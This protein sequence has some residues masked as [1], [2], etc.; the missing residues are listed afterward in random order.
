[1]S[2]C[3]KCIITGLVQGVF[4]RASTEEKANK[5]GVTGYVKNIPE[6]HVEVLICGKPE[7]VGHLKAWLWE[8]PP[9]SHVSNVKCTLVED[10]EIPDTFEI[11]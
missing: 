6:G 5:F 11:R 3:E 4:F 2:L 9:N 8:G 1:M 7:A 10:I